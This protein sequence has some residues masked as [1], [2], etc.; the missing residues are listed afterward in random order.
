MS[1]NLVVDI[2]NTC[3][4]QQSVPTPAQ[5]S[6]SGQV[7]GLSGVQVGQTLDLIHADTFCNLYITGTAVLASGPL[8]VGVQTADSDV[9]GNYTD[10]TS[11]LAQLPT[12]FQ[13]GGVVWLNSGSFGGIYGSGTSGQFVQSG[14]AAYAGFQRVGRYARVL[15]NSGFFIGPVQAGFVTQFKTTG[16]G[17][18]FTYSPGSGT[19]NV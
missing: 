15:F 7:C 17:G 4:S 12:V 3:Q 16:S 14:F 1:A 8:I 6:P 2:G 5:L 10:P 11:G 13:S 19:V 18:G 9:S